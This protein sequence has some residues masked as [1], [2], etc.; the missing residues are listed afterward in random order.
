M[1]EEQ[2]FPYSD[3][4]AK[5]HPRYGVPWNMMLV[6]FAAE[7]IVG[8]LNLTRAL[9]LGGIIDILCAQ[10]LFLW[11]ATWHFMPLSVGREYS[12]SWHILLRSSRYAWR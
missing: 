12:S 11:E 4:L 3:W 7:I 5:L 2:A 8:E 1:A 6:V 9:D 10:A